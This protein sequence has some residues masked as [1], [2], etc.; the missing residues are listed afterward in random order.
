M[1]NTEE[2]RLDIIN[3]CNMFLVDILNSFEQTDH[4]PEGRMIAQLKWLKERA[5]NHSLSLPVDPDMLS[6]LRRVFLDGELCYLAS[7][8][9]KK[10]EEI[11]KHLARLINLTKKSA[12][13]LKVDYYPYAIR[14][15]DALIKQFKIA[16]R[17]L[18]KYEQGLIDELIQTKQSLASQK[19]E[20][21]LKSYVPDYPNFIE[22]DF[23]MDTTDYDLP[24]AKQIFKMV[25]KL[26][27]S[28]VRPDTWITP[29]DADKET[30]DL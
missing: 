5:E 7:S 26:I 3:I 4:T 2:Q 12:L 8:P 14:C 23:I 17:P 19:I 18:D 27:F 9:D 15:L 16:K 28:G 13:L 6:T 21:P 20:P 22:V 25:N 10:Y 29:K 24:K 30:S 1:P 11:E